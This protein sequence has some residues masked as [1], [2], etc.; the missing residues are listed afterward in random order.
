MSEQERINLY[1]RLGEA[2]RRSTIAL[3]ERKAKL[4]EKVVIVDGDGKPVIVSAEHALQLILKSS[5]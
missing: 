5:C 4:G 3:Y 1:A 2:M